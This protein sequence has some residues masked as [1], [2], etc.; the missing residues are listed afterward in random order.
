MYVNVSLALTTAQGMVIPDSALI[1][2]GVRQIVFVETSPGTFEPRQVRTGIRGEGKLQVLSGVQEGEKV[3][4]RANF[5]LDSESKLRA[6]LTKMTG[7][8][9]PQAPAPQGGQHGQH[10]GGQ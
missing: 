6:A 7:T 1:D 8:G 3:V 5:L 4:I 10:G 9:V 2:T